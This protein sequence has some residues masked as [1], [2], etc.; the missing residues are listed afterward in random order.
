MDYRDWERYA[1]IYVIEKHGA[2]D[3]LKAPNDMLKK[4]LEEHMAALVR[5]ECGTNGARIKEAF[6]D[7]NRYLQRFLEENS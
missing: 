5:E 6:K 7:N 1:A 4:D 3:A 2:M